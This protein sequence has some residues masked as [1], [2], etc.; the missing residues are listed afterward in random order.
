MTM[1]SIASGG[2]A[3]TY[4]LVCYV[5]KDQTGRRE[6]YIFD[7]GKYSDDVLTTLGQAFLL[8]QEFASKKRKKPD[9]HTLKKEYLDVGGSNPAFYD[10]GTPVS[11]IRWKASSLFN[12]DD[13]QEKKE[14]I[15][16]DT[17]GQPSGPPPYDNED[18]KV[19][20]VLV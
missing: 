19:K 18:H 13:S 16:V 8:A 6:C 2:D 5:A 12:Y 9:F 15:D 1:I 17:E 3:E 4:D 10:Q 14:Y 11:C 20:G 7:C